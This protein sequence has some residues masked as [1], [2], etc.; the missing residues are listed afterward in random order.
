MGSTAAATTATATVQPASSTARYGNSN[1]N[2][3]KAK[4]NA[5]IA[6]AASHGLSAVT[7][8]TSTTTP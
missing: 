3:N 7:P 2:S 4:M 1:S 5:V 6:K 8:I